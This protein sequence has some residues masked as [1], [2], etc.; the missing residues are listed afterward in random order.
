M[1]LEERQKAI[2]SLA[3]WIEKE[4]LGSVRTLPFKFIVDIE[5]AITHAQAI[6]LVSRHVAQDLT[7]AAFSVAHDRYLKGL[8]A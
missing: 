4:K 2:Q 5:R 3:A 7:D 6:F 8:I 1:K